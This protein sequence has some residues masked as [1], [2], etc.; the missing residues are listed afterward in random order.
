MSDSVKT[1]D[2]ATGPAPIN[3]P[4]PGK[5]AYTSEL[6]AAQSIQTRRAV[7]AAAAELF[8]Q[9][10]FG[11]TTV[12]QIAG[13]AGVSRKTVFAS[14]GGKVELLKLAI[15]WALVGDDQPGSLQSRPETQRLMQETDPVAMLRGWV[16]MTVRISSRL[17]RLTRELMVAAGINPDARTLWETA[18]AQRL[19]G[20]RAFIQHLVARNGLRDD[21][22][23]TAAADIAWIHSDPALYG[24]LVTER[25]WSP[26]R[27]ESWLYETMQ[28]QLGTTSRQTS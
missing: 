23:Q 5:R 14:V 26:A 2:P 20:A 18:Q 27:F 6:R 11:C 25:D 1:P 19:Y 3:A 28:K 10:G 17:A 22:S 24:R 9:N 15:D 8:V 16:R 4:D 12:E 7:V 13:V 21:L